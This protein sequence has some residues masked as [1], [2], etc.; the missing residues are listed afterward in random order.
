MQSLTTTWRNGWPK[1][2]K[3]LGNVLLDAYQPVRMEA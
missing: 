1:D 3:L 2:W